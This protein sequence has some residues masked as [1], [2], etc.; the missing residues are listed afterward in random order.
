MISEISHRALVYGLIWGFW[1]I[2]IAKL[3][4][5]ILEVIS[6]LKRCYLVHI[7][8]LYFPKSFLQFPLCA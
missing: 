4:Y 2:Q 1:K 6:T 5:Y 3:P 7:K 8:I